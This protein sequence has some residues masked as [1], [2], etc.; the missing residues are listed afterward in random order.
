MSKS[1]A[2]RALSRE[3]AFYFFTSI[4]NY[5]GERAASLEEFVKKILDVKIK[6]LEFHL[7]RG[8]FERWVADTLE[9]NILA[10]KIRE[11]KSSKP[12][13]IDLRDRLYLLVSKHYE[14]LK[15]PRSSSTSSV[16][17]RTTTVTFVRPK[18]T[19]S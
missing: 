5:A 18:E 15:N 1:K 3:K 12:I 13:G 6:S 16:K 19:T 8:D 4:G 14:N 10:K 9:D 11:L 2:L 7:Y 17:P